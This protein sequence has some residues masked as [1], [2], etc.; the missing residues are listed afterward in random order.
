M[1][2]KNQ[3]S[4]TVDPCENSTEELLNN[5]SLIVVSNRG[6]VGFSS[7]ED[8]NLQIQRSGGGLVT[9]LRGLAKNINIIWIASATD[10][11]EK[12]WG[13]GK[14]ALDE[15]GRPIELH[16]V[17]FDEDVYNGYYN[18]ISNPLLWF[19]QHS[20]WDFIYGPTI[21]RET[22]QAWEHGYVEANRQFARVVA[23]HV[24]A[25][26]GRALVMLQDYHLYLLP[27]MLRGLLHRPRGSD[28]AI[29]THF[30]HIPWPGSEELR[31]LPS[32]MRQEILDGLSAVDLLGFQTREDGVNFLQSVE[33]HL[34]DASVNY[35]HRRVWYHNHTTLVRDF[36][37]SID[38]PAIKAL[39]QKAETQEIRRQLEE[40]IDDQKL[41][42]RVDRTDPS[43]N[44]VR[45]FQAFGELL[46]LH[47]EYIGKVKF[48]A[49]LVP[50]RLDVEE[51]H[52]YHNAI[53]AAAGWVNSRYG[54]GNWEPIRVI[55]GENYLRA[56]AAL[57]IYDVLLVNSI[58]DGMNLVAKE[59]PVVNQRDGVLIL[60]ERT[61]ASQ[62][63]EPGALIISPCDTYATAAA[64]HQ[65]LIMPAEERRI[66]ANRLRWLVEENDINTWFCDQIKEIS[67]LRF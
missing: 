37:I 43:K 63:L 40:I 61:G 7:D 56:V 67:K 48:I 39:S 52:K 9:A 22:W 42:L 18:V 23:Q 21:T 57:Q 55:T 4:N 50:S 33:A 45:G 51:Y 25:A 24:K 38:V 59:G 32:S 15:G 20:M 65:A 14:V 47:P 28:Q 58:A 2:D 17:P 16:L 10:A 11:L 54:T 5:Q 60:S 53:M 29:L 62:Q 3:I 12:E 30:V 8:G 66:R 31:I 13:H 35:K 44:I 27:R 49:I 26:P 34:P 19:L 41:I 6:P 1:S 36:P 46:E 64:L